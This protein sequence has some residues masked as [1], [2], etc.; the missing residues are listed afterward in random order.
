MSTPFDRIAVVLAVI[1]TLVAVP[2]GTTASTG[3]SGPTGTDDGS[4][5]V[6]AETPEADTTVT[7]I[8]MD[9]NGTAHWSVTVRTRLA[10]DSE[11]DD[12]EA[13]Q[14]QF[15]ANRESYVEQ[16]ERR[17]TGVVSNA[18]ESTG[19]NMTASSFRAETSIQEV[20]RQ[21][22]MVTYSF[23]WTNFGVVDGD[24]IA[25]GDV[26]GGGFYLDDD[27][28]LQIAPPTGYAPTATSPPP[29]ERDGT[30]AVWAGP[31][32]FADR[33]P[34]VRFEPANSAVDSDHEGTNP[35][36]STPLGV[37]GGILLVAIVAIGVFVGSR[38]GLPRQLRSSVHI[39]TAS[40]DPAAATETDDSAEA[41][42]DGDESVE[43][44]ASGPASPAPELATDE[45]R[46]RT[47]LERNDGRMRQAA[48]A[49]ELDWSASK[50]SRVVSGMAEENAVE[51]LRIGRE[52]VI[53]LLENSD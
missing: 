8:A 6:A 29:D 37:V 50:T 36:D 26:F 33:H 17:M 48:V 30:T 28:R 35:W 9:E 52:N 4:A 45:D 14:E 18:A 16:F 12:Y 24:E 43:S 34:T 7:R 46:V 42:S 10:N 40:T 39:L 23:T 13:F 49:E 44:P 47:L 41:R 51:K 31:E 53:D 25:V 27:D 3:Q 2:V 5:I 19:R 11:V 15:R 20:P 38:R 32:S 21:W 22:G 1:L